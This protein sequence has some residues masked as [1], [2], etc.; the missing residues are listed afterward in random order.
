[1]R[2]TGSPT[3]KFLIE[4]AENTDCND[5]ELKAGTLLELVGDAKVTVPLSALPADFICIS[6]NSHYRLYWL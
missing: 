5:Y 4:L 2:I 1:M 6:I 3:R